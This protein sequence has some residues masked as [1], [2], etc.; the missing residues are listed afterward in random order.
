MANVMQQPARKNHVHRNG[1][2]LSFRNA[3]TAK[4][5]ELLP[6]VC[7]EVIPGDKFKIDISSFTRTQPVQTAAFTRIREYYDFYFVPTS[8]LW[9]KFN[10]YIVQTNNYNHA[11]SVTESPDNLEQHPWFSMT[12]IKAYINALSSSKID[13][14]GLP[15]YES[16]VKLLHYLGYGDWS[17]LK[18]CT[19]SFAMNPFPLLAYQ[20]IYNDYYR[21]S[22]WRKSSPQNFN[23]DY[24]FTT[25][26]VPL[27]DLAASV[28]NSSSPLVDTMFSMR[29][30]NYKKDLFMGLLPS[31]QYGDMAYVPVDIRDDVKWFEAYYRFSGQGGTGTVSPD[32]FGMTN[33]AVSTVRNG[34]TMNSYDRIRL[35]KYEGD[36][37]VTNWPLSA[38][39]F[40]LRFAEASQK[41]KEITGSNDMDYRSQ[42]QAHWGVTPSKDSGYKCDWLGGTSSNIV[43]NEV[44]NTSLDSSDSSRATIYGKATGSINDGNLVNFTSDKYGYIIGIYHAVPLLDYANDGVSRT[45]FK[46]K[47]DDYAIPEFENLGF[48]SVSS[49][50]FYFRWPSSPNGSSGD[51]IAEGIFRKNITG[52]GYAPRYYEYKTNLDK[53]NGS[54]LTTMKDW[55]A[56]APVVRSIFASG[57]GTDSNYLDWQRFVVNPKVVDPIFG[58]ASDG[59]VDS[60]QLLI[61][62][63]FD[64]KAVRNLSVHGLPY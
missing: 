52:V 24:I 58:Y 62:A 41:W 25:K 9:D 26:S 47:A 64:I 40:A 31:A 10:N 50:E 53:I 32:Y 29:Y 1:F 49:T 22:Q 43:I 33:G 14:G 30:A 3:F 35:G 21:Y 23:L 38:S 18:N 16:T 42:I 45:F 17:N 34:D 39:V 8:L 54:F 19:V 56:P 63:Y 13:D 20:K 5:G 37:G 15:A 2:D 51:I 11:K 61:G 44:V 57:F 4:V 59:S 48:E 12:G 46:I 28:T 6:V 60:D 7:Q 36:T 27:S 55:V